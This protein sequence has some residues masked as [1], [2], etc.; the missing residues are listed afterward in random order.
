MHSRS[1]DLVLIAFECYSSLGV[2]E[3]NRYDITK[4]KLVL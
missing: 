1:I 2:E 3:M 4:T